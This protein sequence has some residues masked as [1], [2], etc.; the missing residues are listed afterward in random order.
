MFYPCSGQKTRHTPKSEK[1]I[2][3]WWQL[4]HPITIQSDNLFMVTHIKKQLLR[5]SIFPGPQELDHIYIYTNIHTVY[6][7]IYDIWYIYETYP[8][9]GEKKR[10][11][12]IPNWMHGTITG[13][14]DMYR[15]NPMTSCN[16]YIYIYTPR[17]PS[18]MSYLLV[19]PQDESRCL[20]GFD[21]ETCNFLVVKPCLAAGQTLRR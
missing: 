5:W 21:G 16:I 9:A 18:L 17:E 11:R 6:I 20:M 12:N 3:V 14:P 13:D 15:Q 8:W 7:Y 4:A 1:Q 2:M 10:N 19:N